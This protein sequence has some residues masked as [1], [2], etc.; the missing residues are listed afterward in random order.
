MGWR[1]VFTKWREKRLVLLL[2]DLD[3]KE[4]KRE[5]ECVYVC[6]YGELILR[7]FKEGVSMMMN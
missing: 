7:E 5:R 6:V 4:G 3:A 1:G 2:K